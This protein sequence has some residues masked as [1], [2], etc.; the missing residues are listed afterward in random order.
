MKGEKFMH[1]SD[2][3]YKPELNHGRTEFDTGDFTQPERDLW[4]AIAKGFRNRRNTDQTLPIEIDN[5]ENKKPK[6]AMENFWSEQGLSPEEI[7][8]RYEIYIGCRYEINGWNVKYNNAV[9]EFNGSGIDLIC[10]KGNQTLLVRCRNWKRDTIIHERH[11]HQLFGSASK[12]RMNASEDSRVGAAFYTSASFSESAIEAAE[13]FHIVLHEQFYLERFP[14]IKCKA[15][16]HTYYIPDDT[17]YF[18]ISIDTENGDRFCD[19]I[20]EA[21]SSGF[22]HI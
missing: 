20:D 7:G 19:S 10:T 11:I 5:D 18:T 16:T 14:C 21:E 8:R 6:K 1:S 22:R 2:E 3:E 17:E 9:N 15:E 4:T 12:Y 13:K